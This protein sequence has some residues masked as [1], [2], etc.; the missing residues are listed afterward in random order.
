[1]PT[2][3]RRRGAPVPSTISPPRTNTSNMGRPPVWAGR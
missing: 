1:M 2:S 3:A